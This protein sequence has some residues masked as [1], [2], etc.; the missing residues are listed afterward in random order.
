M[1]GEGRTDEEREQVA[2]RVELE[3]YSSRTAREIARELESA[4]SALDRSIAQAQKCREVL[5]KRIDQLRA[6]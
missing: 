1:I 5:E 4:V 2:S 6:K 3:R